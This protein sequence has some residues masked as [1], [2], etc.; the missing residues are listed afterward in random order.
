MTRE[1][2]MKI[3]TENSKKIIKKTKQYREHSLLVP[4]SGNSSETECHIKMSPART[5]AMYG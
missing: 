5:S 1:D 4:P 3:L 2:P